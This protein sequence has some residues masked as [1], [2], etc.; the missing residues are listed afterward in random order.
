MFILVLK[1]GNWSLGPGALELWHF[2]VSGACGSFSLHSGLE[3]EEREKGDGVPLSPL[4]D[5]RH[6]LVSFYK[7][8]HL[9]KDLHLCT[10]PDWGPSL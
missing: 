7:L 5:Y 9:I 8:P 1:F 2:T 6:D 3:V 4:R 10:V